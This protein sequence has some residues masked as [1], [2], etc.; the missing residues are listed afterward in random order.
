MSSLKNWMRSKRNSG[1]K[2]QNT[3]DTHSSP[4]YIVPVSLTMTNE[5]HFS[6]ESRSYSFSSDAPTVSSTSSHSAEMMD[7]ENTAWGPVKK[8]KKASRS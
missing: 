3:F 1:S 5:T 7:D 8:S 2:S 6:L 4:E